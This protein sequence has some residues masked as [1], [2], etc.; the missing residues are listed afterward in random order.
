VDVFWCAIDGKSGHFNFR[1]LKE[2]EERG[3][4]VWR[5]GWLVA[6]D[7]DVDIGFNLASNFADSV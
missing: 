2:S 5:Q 7:I 3:E 6:L 4:E 1:A